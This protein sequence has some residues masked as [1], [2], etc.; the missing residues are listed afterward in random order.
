MRRRVKRSIKRSSPRANNMISHNGVPGNMFIKFKYSD[1]G[2]ATIAGGAQTFVRYQSSIFDPEQAK[3]GGF[4]QNTQP[5]AYAFY[6]PMYKSYCIYAMKVITKVSTNSATVPVQVTLLDSG[7]EQISPANPYQFFNK[8]PRLRRGICTTARPL[9][10]KYYTTVAKSVGVSEMRVKTDDLFTS[11][12]GASPAVNMH[13]AL[14]TDA[15][16]QVGTPVVSHE[17]IVYY[18]V[19]LFDVNYDNLT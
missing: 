16:D 11:L 4:G 14:Y 12:M 13:I 6:A 7:T 17:T 9:T 15:V 10:L 8:Y 3:T 5:Y 2:T 1:F 18:Y 19:K